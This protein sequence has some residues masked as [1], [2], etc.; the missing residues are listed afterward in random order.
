M[1]ASQPSANVITP[2][3]SGTSSRLVPWKN[4]AAALPIIDTIQPAIANTP[5]LWMR[6]TGC[7]QTPL[8]IATRE[9]IRPVETE[10]GAALVSLAPS[11]R[12]DMPAAIEGVGALRPSTNT[13]EVMVIGPEAEALGELHENLSTKAKIGDFYK[14]R[15]GSSIEGVELATKNALMWHIEMTDALRDYIMAENFASIPQA[16]LRCAAN[17]ETEA[18]VV[19]AL[20]KDGQAFCRDTG[21]DPNSIKKMTKLHKEVL[22]CNLQKA[23]SAYSIAYILNCTAKLV[24]DAEMDGMGAVARLG[25]KDVQRY[26]RLSSVLLNNGCSDRESMVKKIIK[27]VGP[28]SEDEVRDEFKAPKRK[29][30]AVEA[31]RAPEQRP[32]E[33]PVRNEAPPQPKAPVQRPAPEQQI[34]AI[35]KELPGVP[36]GFIAKWF[37]T[38]MRNPAKIRAKYDQVQQHAPGMRRDGEEE[39]PGNGTTAHVHRSLEDSISAVMFAPAIEAAIRAEGIDPHHVSLAVCKVFGYPLSPKP[40]KREDAAGYLASYLNGE[41]QR[42]VKAAESVFAFIDNAGLLTGNDKTISINGGT[43]NATGSAILRAVRDAFAG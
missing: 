41:A 22:R 39:A 23:C 7:T 5:G 42:P 12:L 20:V 27:I 21:L 9:N 25:I 37:G 16:C 14:P 24:S 28:E 33:Q 17:D 40:R 3:E 34:A 1:C 26:G 30:V 6:T 43:K 8:I 32:P 29:I 36:L 2:K 10:G 35:Q 15:N 31:V 18:A 13:T 11:R 4:A 19:A 38:G